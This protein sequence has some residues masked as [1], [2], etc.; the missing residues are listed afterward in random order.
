MS[1]LDTKVSVREC[2]QLPGPSML[3]PSENWGKET[4]KVWTG[5]CD[6]AGGR[7][8]GEGLSLNGFY[9]AK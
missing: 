1:V 3:V 6:S 2:C 9:H 7:K 5:T 8:V 4:G